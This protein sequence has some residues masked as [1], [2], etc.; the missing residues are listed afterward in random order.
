MPVPTSESDNLQFSMAL[1]GVPI[2]LGIKLENDNWNNVYSG[3]KLKYDNWSE[4]SKTKSKL[5][6]GFLQLRD[7]LTGYFE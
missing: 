2:W 4:N 3:N 7:P 5:I 6:S 1:G